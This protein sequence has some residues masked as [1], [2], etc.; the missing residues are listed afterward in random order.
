MENSFAAKSTVY[1]CF[2]KMLTNSSLR[3]LK[4]LKIEGCIAETNICSNVNNAGLLLNYFTPIINCLVNNPLLETFIL[5][6]A[7]EKPD[8]VIVI[9][10]N[11]TL[12]KSTDFKGLNQLNN[13]KS[14]QIK[15][16][17]ICNN[18]W[19]DILERQRN[20]RILDINLGFP[21]LSN[22]SIYKI[23]EN[24]YKS[25]T[26]III[27]SSFMS[28]SCNQHSKK[29]FDLAIFSEC[30]Q[31]QELRIE[32]NNNSSEEIDIDFVDFINLH[33]LPL[34]LTKLC[35]NGFNLKTQEL[36]L[37]VTAIENSDKRTL[38]SIVIKDC[39]NGKQFGMNALTLEK[40]ILMDL[41]E[42]NISGFNRDD[43]AEATKFDRILPRFRHE[44]VVNYFYRNLQ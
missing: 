38:E 2:L 29:T 36:F 5:S 30:I 40:L 8:M 23:V 11:V 43:P 7:L 13:L 15:S 27:I 24:N 39:G 33:R 19:I 10:P 9:P 17:G 21:S 12:L 31:L 34:S 14:V 37:Y 25:L 22:F 26:N 16:N 44:S 18:I 32:R 6:I 3:S 41:K 35:I 42:T 28:S 20:L 4:C 1:D